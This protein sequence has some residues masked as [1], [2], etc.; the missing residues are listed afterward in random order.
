MASVRSKYKQCVEIDQNNMTDHINLLFRDMDG[1]N[2]KIFKEWTY[3]P[4]FQISSCIGSVEAFVSADL[5]L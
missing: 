5:D 4:R 2:Q 3:R 1:F